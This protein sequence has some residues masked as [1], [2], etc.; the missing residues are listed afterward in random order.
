MASNYPTSIDSIPDPVPTNRRNSPSLANGQVSQNDAIEAIQTYVGTL[1][2]AD[3]SSLTYRITNAS[4]WLFASGVPAGGTGANGNIYLDTAT[5]I[6]YR[7]AAGSWSAIYTPPVVSAGDVSPLSM[8]GG[9]RFA[10]MP[11]QLV[12]G[13]PG[14]TSQRGF[15][16]GWVAPRNF[17][18]SNVSFHVNTGAVVTNAY[19]AVYSVASNGDLTRI[20]MSANTP[21]TFAAAG[22]KTV[23]MAVPVA[24]TAGTAYS[25][26]L[27]VDGSNSVAITGSATGVVTAVQSMTTQPFMTGTMAVSAGTPAT[28]VTFASLTLTT[29]GS[30]YLEMS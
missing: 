17:T 3:S 20:A 5:G 24:V 18:L 28:P 9:T 26:V 15:C 2:S 19:V 16:N 11:R 29:A 12:T 22:T 30:M 6:I 25:I 10:N 7:K 23:A 4:G 14:L 1:N 21:A 8:A 13:G 27:Y